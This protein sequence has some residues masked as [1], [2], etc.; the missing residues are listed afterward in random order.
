MV[1]TLYSALEGT[2]VRETGEPGKPE[3][4]VMLSGAEYTVDGSYNSVGTD[5]WIPKSVLH[6]D[7]LDVVEESATGEEIE[8]YVADWW[9]R[10]Q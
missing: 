1:R 10:S 5:F 8:I 3:G 7:S 6:E 2:V 4:A 9:L